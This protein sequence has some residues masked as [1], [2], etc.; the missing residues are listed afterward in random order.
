MSYYYKF[1]ILQREN[2]VLEMF[3]FFL[4]IAHSQHSLIRTQESRMTFLILYIPNVLGFMTKKPGKFLLCEV[5]DLF[6]LVG[7]DVP[8]L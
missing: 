8:H 6:K 3:V 2:W 1:P 7:C 5:A 4:F